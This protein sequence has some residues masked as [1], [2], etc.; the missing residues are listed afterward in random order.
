MSA[1]FLEKI[2]AHKRRTNAAKQSMYATIKGHI[3]GEQY[4]R[5]HVFK[6]AVS[7]PDRIN[8]IAEI[9]KASPSKGLI[10][11]EFDALGIAREYEKH[12]AAALSVLTEDKYF[13]GSVAYLKKI[14]DEAKIPVLAKDFFID[15]GQIFEARLNGASAIL[16][17][18][19]ILSDVQ[20]REFLTLAARL[21]LDCLVEVHDREELDRALDCGADIV[22]I[23]HR[24]L[25]TF[26]MDMDLS[27]ELMPLIPD[28]KIV[29]A[30]SGLSN[31]DEIR[32]LRDS[33]VDAFLIGETLMRETD[34]GRKLDE[35]L[36][37]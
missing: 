1:D 22:G 37:D 33:G 32:R 36:T 15:E 11:D 17:V 9:K 34:I 6:Q 23:N 24:D 3:G 13:L 20:I 16:L 12:H 19:A 30:E 10:R 35:L 29:V 7:R 27:A 26:E 2:L 31:R 18:V 8:I 25:K 14:S 28:D 4:A 5:Y 21:D